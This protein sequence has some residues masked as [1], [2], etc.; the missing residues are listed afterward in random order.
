MADSQADIERD[1][2]ESWDSIEEFYKCSDTPEFRVPFWT[3]AL[4][5]IAQLRRAGYDRKLRAGQSL[6]ML[7]VSRSRQH[8]MSPEQPAIAFNFEHGKMDVM[9]GRNVLLRA[10]D[11]GL[12][13]EVK[14]ILERLLIHPI[15]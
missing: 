15:G 5:M 13:T 8:G 6:F 14:A 3:E 12:S 1:F 11:I 2:F 4:Q 7:V 10:I 9:E